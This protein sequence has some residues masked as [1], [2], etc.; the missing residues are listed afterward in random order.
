MSNVDWLLHE[1]ATDWS[2]RTGQRNTVDDE[3]W[4]SSIERLEL[5]PGLRIFLFE[6][7]ARQDVA[8]QMRSERFNR[9]MGGQVTVT[10]GAELDFQ[11]G[12]RVRPS[13]DRALIFR[14]SRRGSPRTNSRPARRSSRQGTVSRSRASSGCSTATF[15]RCC[16]A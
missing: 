6:A 10:G 13:A 7:T 4:H 16:R 9:W 8:L 11:D 15:R 14:P 1:S 12:V 5:G 2:L 3:R